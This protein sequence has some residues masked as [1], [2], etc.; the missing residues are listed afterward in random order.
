MLVSMLFTHPEHRFS[1][2]TNTTTLTIGLSAFLQ[3]FY[4]VHL[5]VLFGG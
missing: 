5:C 1:V 4:M 3:A 2:P